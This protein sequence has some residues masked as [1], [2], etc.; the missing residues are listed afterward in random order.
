MEETGEWSIP[1][2]RRKAMEIAE[3]ALPLDHSFPASNGWMQKVLERG[4]TCN[5]LMGLPVTAIGESVPPTNDDEDEESPPTDLHAIDCVIR[6]SNYADHIGNK[7]LKNAVA[8]VSLAMT[9]I[10]HAKQL[11]QQQKNASSSS[12]TLI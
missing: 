9:K 2:L 5:L 11:Q 10:Q 6:L 8:Q 4:R 12:S 7:D 1:R 3:Q